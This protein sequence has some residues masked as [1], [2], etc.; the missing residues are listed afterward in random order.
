M[1]RILLK[2]ESL[3]ILLILVISFFLRTYRLNEL[4][5]F[6][7]DMGLFFLPAKNMLIHGTIPLVGPETSHP[8]IH[9]GAHWIYTLAGLL[10]LSNYNPLGPAYFI[11][12]LGTF[13][14]LIFYLVAREMFGKNI[15]ILSTIL[16]ATAPLIVLNARVPY[17]T[18]PIPFFVIILFYLV[19][20]WVKD[21]K[22]WLFPVI[23]FLLGVLYNHEITTFVYFIAVGIVLAYGIFKKADWCKKLLNIKIIIASAVSF[24]IPMLPFIIYDVKSGEY[25]QTL[26]FIVWVIYRI[27]KFPLSLVD[28][29][30]KSPGSSPSTIPQFFSYYQELSF[31]QSD[32]MALILLLITAAFIFFYFRKH[33][34]L[35]GKRLIAFRGKIPVSYSLLFLF[36]FV[37]IAGLSTHRVPIEADTLLISP[38]IILLTSMAIM[39]LLKEKLYISL[40]VVVFIAG[41]N[42]YGLV[43][44]NFFTFKDGVKVITYKDKMNAAEEVI[45][46]SNNQPY[47]L[48]GK[49]ELSN[50]KSFKMPYEYLLWWKGHPPSVS[51]VDLKIIVWEKD[52]KITVQRQK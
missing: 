28:P 1:K 22:V 24:I 34:K 45:K 27:V 33:I 40:L 31:S 4:M 13:I 9:H 36:F 43:S 30:F 18:S 51:E 37:G 3:F 25:N 14:V 20:K 16:Y 11:A 35:G 8:W 12:V 2:K 19:Y 32:F 47:N 38:F 39:W 23:T 5:A 6:F 48:I 7:P 10:F 41:I 29:T 26:R 52:N 21:K 17:H 15:A 46:L 50:F 49:G 44:T 42:F